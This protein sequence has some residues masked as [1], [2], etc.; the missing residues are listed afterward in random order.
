MTISPTLLLIIYCLA[1]AGFS[2]LGGLLPGWVRMTHTR[3]Q[4]M[5]SL[6]S[7]LMLG[8]AFYHLLPHSV[9]LL[10]GAGSVDTT[11]W[12]LMVG[13]IVMLLLL[14]VFQFHQHDFSSEESEHHEHPHHAHTHQHDH[15]PEKAVHGLSWIGLA[16]GLG[17]HTLIDGVALGAVMHADSHAGGLIGI[18]VFLAILLHKPLDAMSIVTLMEA[19]GWSRSA[20]MGT[21]LVFALMVPLGALLFFFGVNVVADSR[22]HLVAAALAFSAGAFICIALSDLLPEV[23]FHSHDKAKLTLAFLLG[24][25]LAY[26]IGSV[27]PAGFHIYAH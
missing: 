8:V 5:M 23:H 25:A 26:G 20:R 21:N 19:G 3:T 12:W 2:L 7:G 6:V 10:G 22:N 9:A 13:L 17:V 11:V 18:G 1:V 15:Q 16:L 4:L 27:E 24:I 14:R